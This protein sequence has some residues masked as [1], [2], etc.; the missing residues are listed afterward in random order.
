[1]SEPAGALLQVSGL[2][3]SFAVP[4]L[5]ALDFRMRAGEVHALVGS[6]GAGKSTLARIL[7]GMLPRDGGAIHFAGREHAPRT[8][9]EAQACGVT[10]M[11]QELNV[12]PTLTVAENLFLDRLPARFGWVD[13]RRLRREAALALD[14]VGLGALD[15]DTPAA[16]LGVG[17]QQ[18]VELAAALAGECR[19]LILDEPTA[20]LTQPE[21]ERL[22]ENIQRLRSEG[23][24][25]LYISHR[26]DELRRIADRVSI[27][28]DGQLVATM[29]IAQTSTDEMVRLMAGHEMPRT[30]A[31]TASAARGPVA[32]RVRGLR[33]GPAVRDV[34][35][36]VHRGEIFGLFGLV[37]AGRTETLRAIFG[38]DAGA[39]GTVETGTPLRPLRVRCPAEAIAAG[40][41]LV[42]EDRKKDGLLLPKSLTENTTLAALSQHAHLGWLR[43]AAEA[44]ST[45]GIVQRLGV[46]CASTQQPVA[47]LSGGNQQKIVLGRWLL[48]DST[49][50]LLDEPTRGVDAA[51][52]DAIHTLLR[53]L[54]AEGKAIVVVSS[55]VPELMSLCH[56]LIVLSAGRTVAEFSPADWSMEKLTAAAFSGHLDTAAPC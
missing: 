6:N 23:V 32:L 31:S 53:E 16:A 19:L 47:T 37:G 26:M 51:A 34:S 40:L 39:Q 36:D 44:R 54:A 45:A 27:L 50:L 49:V 25:I 41:A 4:V 1:M 18:Q 46:Q 28:R 48:R 9:R 42:P 29:P 56:R 11:L 12:F 17:R 5:R 21:T 33:R 15:P 13:R 2:D 43:P 3:K 35:F 10:L 20:A 14:R 8:R 22:F 24:A 38:A 7:A 55:E 30:P 52:K